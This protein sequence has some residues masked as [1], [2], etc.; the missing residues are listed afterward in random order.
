MT[1]GHILPV[2]SGGGQ[3]V[4]LH[5]RYCFYRMRRHRSSFEGDIFV[6]RKKGSRKTG[7]EPCFPATSFMSKVA[8]GAVSLPQ[9]D[10]MIAI[11]SR[12]DWAVTPDRPGSGKKSICTTV[13]VNEF[14]A[15]EMLGNQHE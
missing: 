12:A 11:T 3:F 14:P 7:Y 10:D 9:G 1:L 5:K 8:S 13:G 15:F 6:C 2:F 4:Y